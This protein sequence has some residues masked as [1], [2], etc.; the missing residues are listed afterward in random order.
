MFLLRFYRRRFCIFAGLLEGKL[1]EGSS[2][3]EAEG[4]CPKSRQFGARSS[5]LEVKNKANITHK[6]LE[7]NRY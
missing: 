1:E 6:E 2:G 5:K 3:L 7:M 4:G